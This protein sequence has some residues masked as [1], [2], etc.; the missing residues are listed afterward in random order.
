MELHWR[1]VV[2]VKRSSPSS[3]ISFIL[4]MPVVVSSLT[5]VRAAALLA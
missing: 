3:A 5:P 4:R 1:S 2:A